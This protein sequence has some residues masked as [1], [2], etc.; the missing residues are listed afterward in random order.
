MNEKRY[1]V[2]FLTEAGD[3]KKVRALVPASVMD[4]P[5]V[6]TK[7]IA[8]KMGKDVTE[9]EVSNSWVYTE[10]DMNDVFAIIAKI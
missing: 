8:D 3:I 7:Y 10:R 1:S 4:I 9:I 6:V 5:Q 2:K